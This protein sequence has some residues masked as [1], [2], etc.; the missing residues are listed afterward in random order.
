MAI[1]E[2][3]LFRIS[4]IPLPPF[5]K[6]DNNHLQEGEFKVGDTISTLLMQQTKVIVF[7]SVYEYQ[8]AHLTLA[9]F[10]VIS[11]NENVTNVFVSLSAEL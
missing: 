1:H 8:I 11:A 6:N 7:N 10:N 5:G 9:Y 4:P 3:I 2:K